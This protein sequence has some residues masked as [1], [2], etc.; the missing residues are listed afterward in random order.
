MERK[1]DENMKQMKNMEQ[2]MDGKLEQKIDG[3]LE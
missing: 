3:K 2:R 1:M